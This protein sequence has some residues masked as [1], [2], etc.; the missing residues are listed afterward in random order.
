MVKGSRER[1]EEELVK[2]AAR[3]ASPYGAAPESMS[4]IT[5][6]TWFKKQDDAFD[7][8]YK[9]VLSGQTIDLGGSFK[10]PVGAQ[11]QAALDGAS[12]SAKT[13]IAKVLNT[14]LKPLGMVTSGEQ[15]HEAFKEI[16][17]AKRAEQASVA[18]T[19]DRDAKRLVEAYKTVEKSMLDARNAALKATGD[20]DKIAKLTNLDEAYAHHQIFRTAAENAKAGGEG[21]VKLEHL[22]KAVEDTTPPKLLVRGEGRMQDLTEPSKTVFEKSLA[23][24]KD[25]LQRRV[26]NATAGA[27]LTGGGGATMGPAG[28]AIVPAIAAGS[29]VAAARPVSK[30]LF[31]NTMAQKFLAKQ[32]RNKTAA[33]GASY[34]LGTNDTVEE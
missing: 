18:K 4:D 26:S 12:D 16:R 31:G 27:V 32:M 3:R 11:V 19:G 30:L 25:A 15:W 22:I 17:K 28:L 20:E 34:P 21:G 13:D 29:S 8:G 7:K 33:M 5:R 1:A 6:G 24:G 9:E 23:S 2:I 10:V 14:N